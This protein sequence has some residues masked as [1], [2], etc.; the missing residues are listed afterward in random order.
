MLGI[1]VWGGSR[2]CHV[3]FGE[4]LIDFLRLPMFVRCL[5]ELLA[6]RM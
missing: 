2:N 6:K 3:L 1:L 4:A 5:S